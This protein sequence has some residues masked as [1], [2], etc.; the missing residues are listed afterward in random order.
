V[1]GLEVNVKTGAIKETMKAKPGATPGQV[2][3]ESVTAVVDAEGNTLPLGSTSLASLEVRKNLDSRLGLF[4]VGVVGVGKQD[5]TEKTTF[6]KQV[7]L[8]YEVTRDLTLNTRVGENEEGLSER[9]VGLQ[10]RTTLPDVKRAK[11]GDVTPPKIER[12]DVYVLGPDKVQVLWTTDEVTRAD[13]RLKVLGD[14]DSPDQVVPERSR[15]Y[16]YRHE[17]VL[18]RLDPESE[19][20]LTLIVRDLNGNVT[21]SPKKTFSTTSAGEE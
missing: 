13:L 21:E 2:P 4:A 7:G 14:E 3:S 8:D 6:Q 5:V 18:E 11:K 17:M 16:E 10:Y 12:F 20:G 19:Y 1:G 9:R 15:E